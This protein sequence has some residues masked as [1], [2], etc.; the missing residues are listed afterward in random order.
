MKHKIDETKHS[1]KIMWGCV[2]FAVLAIILMA[3]GVGG[4]APS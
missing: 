3:N 4:G 1:M 2:I